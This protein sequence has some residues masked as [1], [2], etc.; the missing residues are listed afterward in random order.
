MLMNHQQLYQNWVEIIQTRFTNLGKW[1]ALGLALIS[2]GMILSQSCQVSRISEVL[3]FIGRL[4]SVE[5]RLKRWLC[6]SRI[7]VELCCEWWVRWLW[8]CCDLERPVLLVDETKIGKRVASMVVA[9]AFDKRA[10]PVMWRCYKAD[11]KSAY[12][13]EGQVQLIISL[14]ERVIACLPPESRP[15][16]QAD[17]GLGSSSELMK[18]CQQRGW[19]YLFRLPK[20]IYF[21][22][23]RGKRIKL[24]ALAHYNDVWCGFGTL[25][26]SPQRHVR[27]LVF[28]AWQQGQAEPWCL[29]SNDA[30]VESS[31]Y[32]MRMWQE[33]SFKD[34]KSAGWQW[35]TSRLEDAERSS[36]LLLAMSLAYAW[37][38]TQGTFVLHSEQLIRDICDAQYN[39]FSTFRAGLRFFKRMIYQPE[40]IFVGLFLVPRYKP[41]PE[42]VP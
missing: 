8:S 21:S 6:N 18:V 11:D 3:G 5:K 2:F 4:G 9:L 39:L 10:I 28:V 25:F 34:L 14:L 16:I 41:L 37:V 36:R 19:F 12:P 42:S 27:S 40:K 33:L 22:S 23:R 29:A 26:G 32:A 35:Q 7:D 13:K 1:Q 17:R 20:N 38:M 24:R 30:L 15:L 31:H